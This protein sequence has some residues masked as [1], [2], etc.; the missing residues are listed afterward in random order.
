MRARRAASAA[1][2]AVSFLVAGDVGAQ[3]RFTDDFDADLAGWQLIGGHA[4]NIIDSGDPKHGRVMELQPD[5]AIFALIKDSDQWGDLSI[6][7]DMLF[8]DDA[9]NYLGI[10][11]KKGHGAPRD[12]LAAH[13]WF[14]L[15]FSQG[16]ELARQSREKVA[17]KMTP[18]QP[19]DG[20][21]ASARKPD[22]QDP[23]PT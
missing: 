6:Q 3:V 8:P 13:M 5:G 20:R 1:L 18:G 16:F 21:A 4:I 23:S 17:A 12:Y 22:R 14:N 7:G 15:S 9:S 19:W 10:M 11:Y 2:A